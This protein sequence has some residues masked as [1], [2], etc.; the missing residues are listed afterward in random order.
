V[1]SFPPR[2][3]PNLGQ[4]APKVAAVV[5]GMFSLDWEVLRQPWC[6]Q[7]WCFGPQLLLRESLIPLATACILPGNDT[8]D[9]IPTKAHSL[10]LLSTFCTGLL[11]LPAWWRVTFAQSHV[12]ERAVPR[13]VHYSKW[14]M[15]LRNHIRT[16]WNHQLP[17][18]K[19]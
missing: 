9:P 6:P 7:Q 12:G 17:S 14:Q 8:S 2:S 1:I 18:Q 4:A 15:F 11:A 5:A 3:N 19:F 10:M 13:L 16:E